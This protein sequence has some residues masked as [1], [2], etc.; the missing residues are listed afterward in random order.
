VTLPLL[1]L[2]RTEISKPMVDPLCRFCSPC[3]NGPVARVKLPAFVDIMHRNR[4]RVS[5][6][7]SLS[8]DEFLASRIEVREISDHRQ[9][10]RS[11]LQHLAR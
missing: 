2:A 1:P 11:S 8:R 9:S 7:T 5:S 6:I 3:V 4:F 10:K